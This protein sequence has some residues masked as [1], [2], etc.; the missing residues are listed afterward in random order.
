MELMICKSITTR[1]KHLYC[2][3]EVVELFVRIAHYPLYHLE[4]VTTTIQKHLSD[5][6]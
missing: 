1:H 4:N 2:I 3:A 5:K 6:L